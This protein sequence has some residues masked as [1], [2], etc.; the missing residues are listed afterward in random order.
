MGSQLR[1]GWDLVDLDQC[2]SVV[3]LRQLRMERIELLK[4]RIGLYHRYLRDGVDGDVAAA[5]LWLIRK[6][7]I[8]LAT[9]VESNAEAAP[10]AEQENH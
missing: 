8:E 1:S 5:Y 10:G 2:R 6:D 3:F 4:A 9:L 7:E